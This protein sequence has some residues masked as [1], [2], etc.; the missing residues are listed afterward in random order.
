MEAVPTH[1]ARRD[2]NRDGQRDL[3]LRFQI[4]DLAI[5]CGATSLTLTGELF[6]GHAIIGSN[7]IST[8]G[9]NPNRASKR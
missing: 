8:T 6:D 7:P 2:V 3:V 1:L 4:L 5:E 9:C